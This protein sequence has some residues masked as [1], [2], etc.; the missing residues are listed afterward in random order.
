MRFSDEIF[1]PRVSI[2]ARKND[3]H[4][5]RRVPAYA[6]SASE[7]VPV[8]GCLVTR[9]WRRLRVKKIKKTVSSTLFIFG[10]E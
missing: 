4:A 9:V 7:N 3:E 1:V 5:P 2:E 10:A 6:R 8:K